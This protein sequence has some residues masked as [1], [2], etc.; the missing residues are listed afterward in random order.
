MEAK[1]S[2]PCSQKTVTELDKYF[3]Y[4][5]YP[6]LFIIF[7]V[8]EVFQVAFFL[9]FSSPNDFKYF[10]FPPWKQPALPISSLLISSSE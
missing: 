8:S 3:G 1:C 2:L 10:Y 7:P 6:Y 5:S 4:D 9:Q